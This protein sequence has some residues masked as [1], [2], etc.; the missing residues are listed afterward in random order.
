MNAV[1]SMREVT[2]YVRQA[3]VEQRSGSSMISASA[4]RMIDMIHEIFQ[5]AAGQ[6]LESEKIVATMEKVRVIAEGNGNYAMEMG[7]SLTLLSEA[8]RGLDEE[9]RRFRVRG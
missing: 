1:E 8:I 2:R 5:V 9:I 6:A 7:E 4:E 3:M